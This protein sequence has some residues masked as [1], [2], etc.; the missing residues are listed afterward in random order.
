MDDTFC[1]TTFFFHNERI[2]RAGYQKDFGDLLGHQLMKD[3]KRKI[4]VFGVQ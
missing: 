2:I 1:K 3:F 4:K